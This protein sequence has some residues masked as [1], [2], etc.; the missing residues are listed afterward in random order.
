MAISLMTPLLRAQDDMTDVF[1]RPLPEDAAPYELQ[2]YRVLCDS[3]ASHITF[4]AVVSVYQRICGADL[5]ADPLVVL[6]NNLNLIPAAAESWEP[7][8]DG[9]TWTFKLRPGQVWSD[10]TPLTAYDYEASYRF[11]ATPENGYDFVWMWQGVIANWSEAVAGEVP[12]EEIGY[13]AIDDLTIQVTTVAPF[14]PLPNT[15][16]FWAPIQKAALEAH[17]PNYILDPATSVS[18]GPFMLAEYVPGDVVRHVVNPTYNGFRKPILQAYEAFYGNRSNSFA[19]YQS[20]DVDQVGYETLSAADLEI[21]LN[22]PA[23]SANLLPTPGD[24]RTDYLLFDTFNP[25]FNDQRVRLAFAKALDRESI[26]ANIIGARVAIPAYSFLAP[27]FPASDTSGALKDIQAYDCDAAKQLLA[28]AGFPNGEGFPA[29]TL[30]LRGE[31]DAVRPRFDAAAASISSC[32]NVQIEV[33]NMEFSA[34][35]DALL[36]RPTTLQFGAVSYGMDYLD[37]ANMLGVW[38]STGRHSWVNPEFDSLVAEASTL[39]GDIDK[40]TE[41]FQQAERILVEDVGGIFLNH[42]IQTEFYQPYVV[43]GFR[44]LNAQGLPGWQWGN[45]GNWG[46]VYISNEVLNYDTYR[47]R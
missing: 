9:L 2:S 16:F 44:E 34:Y 14:P 29:L 4:T 12:V 7:S 37:P 41:M 24:F 19:A 45:D 22:D 23:L 40:R 33:N 32:L 20:H 1:G 15:L 3:T 18:A 43:G 30:Q 17:G 10:G 31:S 11:M 47:T 35:M 38:V 25:P 21:I 46:T 27:G 5:F 42:R 39:V 6:D 26:V 8:A 13:K 36:A 28:D